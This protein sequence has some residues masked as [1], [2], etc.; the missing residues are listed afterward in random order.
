MQH[1]AF[2]GVWFQKTK[3]TC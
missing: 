3:Q 1:L 2:K